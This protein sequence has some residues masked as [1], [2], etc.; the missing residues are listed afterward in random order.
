MSQKFQ[1]EIGPF[2]AW[3]SQEL[4]APGEMG[5]WSRWL[6]TSRE[7]L[8]P[9]RGYKRYRLVEAA[10]NEPM[11]SWLHRDTDGSEYPF[12]Y[13]GGELLPEDGSDAPTAFKTG[14]TDVWQPSVV[15]MA[16]Q[17]ESIFLN[18]VNADATLVLEDG[19]NALTDKKFDFAQPDANWTATAVLSGGTL[20]DG[21]YQVRIAQRD[22]TGAYTVQ[23]EPAVVK[24]V[25]I[26]GGG[27]FGSISVAQATWT[28]DARADI[29]RIAISAVGEADAPAVYLH[30][31]DVAIATTTKVITTDTA[32]SSSQAFTSRNGVYRQATMPLANVDF[33]VLHIGRFWIFSRDT[34]EV[35]FSE[36]GQANH[37]YSTSGV[38]SSAE[39][40]WNSPC[41]AAA[42][43]PNGLVVLTTDSVHI[44]TGDARSDDSGT[45]PT[46]ARQLYTTLIDADVGGVAHNAI[47]VIGSTVYCMTTLGPARINGTSLNLLLRAKVRTELDSLDW[48]YAVRWCSAED[49]DL[50]YWC[51]A[52]TRKTNASRP[53]DGASVAGVP[54]LILR[55]DFNHDFWA[56]PIQMDVTHLSCRKNGGD[57]VVS[58]KAYLMAMSP[59][60]YALQ[61]NH[62]M[63]GGGADDVTG[64]IYD[65]ALATAHSTTS[66]TITQSGVTNDDYNGMLAVLYYPTVDTGFPGIIAIK[67]ITDTVVSGS[68]VTISWA[69]ALTVPTSTKWTVRVGGRAAVLDWMGSL[70]AYAGGRIPAGW[71]AQ[72]DS[73]KIEL[74]DVIGV[75]A[76]A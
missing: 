36:R 62:G 55:Y 31:Q 5:R 10:L 50:G 72:L 26:T 21:V 70:R 65:G 51:I 59:N 57:N 76:I 34:N 58:S 73:V 29:W 37:W 69:G 6:E 75:E 49:P 3:T 27:G 33:G 8:W 39:S 63:S 35:Y 74:A 18:G 32:N 16:D 14:L 48:T 17:G 2:L 67:V 30:L 43:A 60:G 46:Y 12:Y 71:E 41:R 1:M 38:L 13:K 45:S 53:M 7:G 24:E 40:G 54:D 66:A 4:C 42:S 25:T 28:P 19:A 47:N 44:I 23:S 9:N 52:V 61:L 56:C 68:N 15:V 64:T 22:T 11:A 20:A